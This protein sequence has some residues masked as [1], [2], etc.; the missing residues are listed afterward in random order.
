MTEDEAS[1]ALRAWLASVDAEATAIEPARAALD[2]VVHSHQVAPRMTG[3]YAVVTPLGER[4][5]GAADHPTYEAVTIDGVER[6][7]ETVTR[8]VVRLWRVEVFAT[9]ASAVA[10]LFAGALQSSR[11]ETDLERMKV[12]LVTRITYPREL[13]GERWEGRA[14]FDVEIADLVETSV[15]I[16]VIDRG[17]IEITGSGAVIVE[18]VVDYQRT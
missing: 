8:G 15:L 3:A 11:A 10:D 18:T 13:V 2:G 7:V 4:D 9:T 5:D 1:E 12:R 14:A 17:S 6:I 16:D